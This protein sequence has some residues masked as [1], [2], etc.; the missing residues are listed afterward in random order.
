[1]RWFYGGMPVALK[2]LRVAQEEIAAWEAAGRGTA[3]A[4]G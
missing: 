3:P 4:R 1:M 2:A